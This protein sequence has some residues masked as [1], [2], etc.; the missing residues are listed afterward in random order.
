MPERMCIVTRE[1]K[2]EV[3][4]IR[5]VR[6]PDGTVTPD[7]KR[8]LPGRGVW[9]SLSRQHVEE[10]GR[11]GAFA[12]GLE[13]PCVV[14]EQLAEKVSMLLRREAV[15]CLS[16]A[17]KA[18]QALC[19]FMKVEEALRRGPV[20]VLLHAAGSGADGCDKLNRLAQPATEIFSHFSPKELD[21]AFGR[22]NVVHA[23][24]TEGGLADKLTFHV[25]RLAEYD[26]LKLG[27][28]GQ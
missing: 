16:L 22:A 25:H 1:V 15:D 3:R 23:A 5:F 2:D 20:R 8:K 9:V 21:L 11:K 27:Q 10:A 6:A 14:P 19:G 28:I 4:L 12:R 17:R 18:G 24:V 13:G 7:L 26:G